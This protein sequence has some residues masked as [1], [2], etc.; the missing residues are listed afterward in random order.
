MHADRCGCKHA[1]TQRPSDPD[2]IFM[3]RTPITH[4]LTDSD[5]LSSECIECYFCLVVPHLIILDQAKIWRNG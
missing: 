4:A 2:D 1:R 5:L 3:T